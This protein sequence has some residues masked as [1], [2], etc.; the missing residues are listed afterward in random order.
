MLNWVYII[1]VPK[2][3]VCGSGVVVNRREKEK[4]KRKEKLY[5]ELSLNS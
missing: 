4:K 1:V 3:I 5:A 2:Q